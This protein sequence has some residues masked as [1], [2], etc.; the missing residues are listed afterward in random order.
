VTAS[1]ADAILDDGPHRSVL[2]DQHTVEVLVA[3]RDS[4][5]A[6]ATKRIE[7]TSA[8]RADQGA[9]VFHQRHRFDA[10][11]IRLMIGLLRLAVRQQSTRPGA[12]AV[13]QGTYIERTGP[14]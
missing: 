3:R 12:I 10:R 14:P 13:M 8:S 2:F 1:A 6:G 5:R 7:K 11:M 4:G 9:E